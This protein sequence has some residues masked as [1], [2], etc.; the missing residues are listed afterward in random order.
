MYINLLL[1]DSLGDSL[2]YSML[3]RQLKAMIFY[4]ILASKL[5]VGVKLELLLFCTKKWFGVC[6]I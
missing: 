2:P 6:Q 1:L 5:N 3:V 4:L